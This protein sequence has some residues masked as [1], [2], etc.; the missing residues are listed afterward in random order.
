MGFD[1]KHQ[2]PVRRLSV[3]W[4]TQGEWYPH[5]SIIQPTR[6]HRGMGFSVWLRAR[7]VALLTEMPL[8][9]VREQRLLALLGSRNHKI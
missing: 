4:K 3:E 9:E 5:I 7:P 6:V 2:S 8:S 1:I